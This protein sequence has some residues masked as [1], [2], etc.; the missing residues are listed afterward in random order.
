M[1]PL[2]PGEGEGLG[3]TTYGALTTRPLPREKELYAL[4]LIAKEVP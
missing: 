4:H 2:P 3:S 1:S